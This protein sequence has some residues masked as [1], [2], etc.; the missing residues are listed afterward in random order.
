MK[1]ESLKSEKFRKL[2]NEEMNKVNGGKYALSSAIPTFVIT[3]GSDCEPCQDPDEE[4]GDPI[5]D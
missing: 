5:W 2:E 3:G 1:L 4:D